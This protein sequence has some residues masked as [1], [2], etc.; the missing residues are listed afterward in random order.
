MQ[1]EK[2]REYEQKQLKK[3]GKHRRNL[4]G[5]L[6]HGDKP[7]VKCTVLGKRKHDVVSKFEAFHSKLSQSRGKTNFKEM[8]AHEDFHSLWNKSGE[9]KALGMLHAFILLQ[10]Y[11]KGAIE[12][13]EK[14]LD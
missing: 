1:V 9:E 10:P 8:R 5:E 11:I 13:E 2:A 4:S 14:A 7:A 6:P 3:L 12:H